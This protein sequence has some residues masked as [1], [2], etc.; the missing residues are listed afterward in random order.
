MTRLAISNAQLLIIDMQQRLMPHIAEREFVL[1]Q[2]VRMIRGAAAMKLPITLSEQYPQGLGAT[3]AEVRAA[4]ETAGAGVAGETPVVGG[5]GRCDRIEK[6]TFSCSADPRGRGRL[7]SLER[8]HVLMVGIE[9]H[10]CVLQSALDLLADGLH[11]VILADAVGSRR[12]L[13]RQIAI[14]RMR[15]AGAT[16]STVESAIYEL[17]HESGTDLFKQILPIVK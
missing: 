16:I 17:M 15:T 9:T 7:K 13:D 14:E 4:F 12:P 3:V 10:V 1:E 5:Q 11:P 2:A 8:P 6:L